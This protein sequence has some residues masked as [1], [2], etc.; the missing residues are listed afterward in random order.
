MIINRRIF[1]TII[2]LALISIILSA[3]RIT[4]KKPENIFAKIDNDKNINFDSD[5]ERYLKYIADI[6][7][8]LT[9]KD[10]QSLTNEKL[11][12]MCKNVTC[13]SVSDG[14]IITYEPNPQDYGLLNHGVFAIYQKI[15]SQKEQEVYTLFL[16]GAKHIKYVLERKDGTLILAGEYMEVNPYFAFIEAY[17][18]VNNQMIKKS[19][20]S[21]Y[22][23]EDYIIKENGII[24]TQAGNI[25]N[26]PQQYN[27]SSYIEEI[28]LEKSCD[29]I[30]RRRERADI[31]V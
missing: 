14:R 6:K 20:V 15:S 11:E 27:T 26:S 28:S 1:F 19:V 8:Y 2:T 3:I 10:M 22:I 17:E 24:Y 31:K 5:N 23:N 25:D 16:G 29:S 4:Y 9:T 7:K 21:D 13:F 30:F 18:P 12:G